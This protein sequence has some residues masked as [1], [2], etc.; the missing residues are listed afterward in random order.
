MAETAPGPANAPPPNCVASARSYTCCHTVSTWRE[1]GCHLDH[2]PGRL[3]PLPNKLKAA[4][5]TTRN[6]VATARGLTCSRTVNILRERGCH[7]DRHAGRVGPSA[8]RRGSSPSPRNSIS[9]NRATPG[10]LNRG[11]D[12]MQSLA[13][14]HTQLH[15]QA[16]RSPPATPQPS[17][18]PQR[19]APRAQLHTNSSEQPEQGAQ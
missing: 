17:R 14:L 11:A 6:R 9:S 10:P 12:H 19:P 16:S 3:P 5:A 1:Q 2:H 13:G 4:K 15:P 18:I 8:W 7:L